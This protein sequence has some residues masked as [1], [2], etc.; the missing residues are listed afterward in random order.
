MIIVHHLE[1]SRS[2]RV[3]WLLEELGLPYEV[4]HYAR[5]KTMAAPA[6][7]RRIHPLGKSPIIQDGENT[8]AETG[9]II[10][11]LVE[12]A[13]GRLGAP[14]DRQSVLRYRY[15]LHYAEGSVMTNLL[16]TMV[17][18]MVPLLGKPIQKKLAP[19]VKVHLDFIEAEL[20]KRPWFAGQEFTAADVMMSF[21]LEFAAAR[22]DGLKGRPNTKAWLEKI[23][24]RPAYQAALERGGPYDFA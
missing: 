21:P 8:I 4:Q 24:A 17:V 23:H 10:E 20:G 19:L 18:G 2:Q 22:M 13:D 9:A 11:Y 3:L 6:E 12:K 1:N 7:L 14:G 5:A 15:F 16:M